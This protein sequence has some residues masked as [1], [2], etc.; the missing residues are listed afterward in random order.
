[1]DT[2]QWLLYFLVLPVAVDPNVVSIFAAHI[3][4]ASI[5]GAVGGPTNCSGTLDAHMGWRVNF[6]SSPLPFLYFFGV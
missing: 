1:M 5:R 6:R 3:F 2:A 4:V